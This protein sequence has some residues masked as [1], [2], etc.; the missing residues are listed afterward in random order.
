MNQG[1]F[2]HDNNQF[3]VSYELLQLF[4]WLLEHEQE[5]MRKLINKVIKNGLRE[6]IVQSKH[7][8]DQEANDLLQ[9]HILDLFGLLD[10]MVYDG[11]HHDEFT[12]LMQKNLMPAIDHVDSQTYGA[13]Y[14]SSLA[15]SIETAASAIEIHPEKDAKAI[16]CKELLK[17]WKPAK[18]T[19][20]N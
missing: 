5:S 16:L 8:D 17:N 4:S 13:T 15:Q 9:Q 20:F 10:A 3:V 12:R 1:P 2:D 14:G 11:I 7:Q 6:R 18:K 19:A